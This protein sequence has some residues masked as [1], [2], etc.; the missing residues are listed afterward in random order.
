[1]GVR[2]K[3]KPEK[4]HMVE[5]ER[6]IKENKELIIGIL[7][8]GGSVYTDSRPTFTNN[9]DPKIGMQIF[10]IKEYVGHETIDGEVKVF[11]SETILSDEQEF[12]NGIINEPS[13][14]EVLKGFGWENDET[15]DIVIWGDLTITKT[16]E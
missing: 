10:D 9:Y 2:Y 11:F 6:F 16:D 4:G 5:K 14:H 3:I 15:T 8:K 7:W 13:Y 1:M 12:L